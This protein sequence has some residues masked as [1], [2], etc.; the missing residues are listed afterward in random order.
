MI[1]VVHMLRA[2]AVHSFEVPLAKLASV[3]EPRDSGIIL[4][5]TIQITI[6]RGRIVGVVAATHINLSADFPWMIE[7]WEGGIHTGNPA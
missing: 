4:G 6:I 3:G 1:F 7:D 2:V 5:I